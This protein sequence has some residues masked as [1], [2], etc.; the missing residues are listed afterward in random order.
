M[1]INYYNKYIKYKN[2]YLELKNAVGGNNMSL[3]NIDCDKIDISNGE[4]IKII[5]DKITNKYNSNNIKCLTC[6]NLSMK[7]ITG[8]I[9]KINLFNLFVNLEELNLSHNQ[10]EN[11]IDFLFFPST[12]KKINLSNNMLSGEIKNI[13]HLYNLKSLNISYNYLNFDFNELIKLPNL[14]Y[15]DISYNNIECEIINQNL[16]NFEKIEYLNISNNKIFGNIPNYFSKLTNIEYLNFSNTLING[17]FDESILCL[18]NIDY[19]DFTI[20]NFTINNIKKNCFSLIKNNYGSCWN[21]SIIF[22]F[23]LSD[24]TSKN[25]IE[26]FDKYNTFDKKYNQII[27][28]DKKFNLYN[29]FIKSYIDSIELIKHVPD[30]KIKSDEIKTVDKGDYD[31]LNKIMKEHKPK[32]YLN[33]FIFNK[34]INA[35]ANLLTQIHNR[36]KFLNINLN[37]EKTNLIEH[38]SVDIEEKTQLLYTEIFPITSRIDIEGGYGNEQF[39]FCLLLAIIILNKKIKFEI[40]YNVNLQR[41]FNDYSNL[42]KIKFVPYNNTIHEYDFVS[43]YNSSIGIIVRIQE[44]VMCF[45]ECNGIKLFNNCFYN[46]KTIPFDYGIMFNNINYLNKYGKKFTIF[47]SKNNE[48]EYF[49]IKIIMDK[50]DTIYTVADSPINNLNTISTVDFSESLFEV[51]K[52]IFIQMY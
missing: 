33:K 36:I 37:T 24:K 4:D 31:K 13:T 16:N 12:L 3:N 5:I 50:R 26:Y 23:L 46:N 27:Q 14:I 30:Y 44:H 10:L 52:F 29:I 18:N 2:K 45:Y 6:L 19:I 43:A 7:N 38:I 20:D 34:N 39:N 21:L 28:I 47:K 49:V 25:I 32:L 48:K 11:N 9:N 35:M 15:L 42:L 51:D 22:I 17:N 1:I 40:F 41:N 8:V